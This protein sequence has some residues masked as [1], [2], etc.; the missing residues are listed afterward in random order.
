MTRAHG[1]SIQACLQ[2]QCYVPGV[3]VPVLFCA[4]VKVLVWDVP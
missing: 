1:P 2:G 4:G 3:S